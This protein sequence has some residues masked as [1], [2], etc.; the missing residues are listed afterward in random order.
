MTV[1]VIPSSSSN[2][3]LGRL[4]AEFCASRGIST[5]QLAEKLNISKSAASRLQTG[6][7]KLGLLEWISICET[8]H[9]S[10]DDFLERLTEEGLMQAR[11]HR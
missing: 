1:D 3:R 2:Q 4:L 8:L 6:E 5:R 9:I 7:R 11:K 10:I